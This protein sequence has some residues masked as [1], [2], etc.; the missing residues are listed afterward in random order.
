LFKDEFGRM[1]SAKRPV[2]PY[3]VPLDNDESDAYQKLRIGERVFAPAAV[4]ESA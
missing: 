2:E 3:V 1:T 4:P